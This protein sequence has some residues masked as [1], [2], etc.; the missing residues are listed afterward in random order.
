MLYLAEVIHNIGINVILLFDLDKKKSHELNL[1]LNK[2][3]LKYSNVHFEDEIENYLNIHKDSNDG[4][5][6]SITSPIAIYNMHLDNNK[7]LIG[8]MNDLD[9]LI[10][11]EL[12]KVS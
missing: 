2:E 5:F 12:K 1:E 6:K 3:L 9:A 4:N 10:K 8:L 11:N 7:D